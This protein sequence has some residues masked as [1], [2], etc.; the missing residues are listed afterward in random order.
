MKH[1][2]LLIGTL[3]LLVGL[4][5]L[6]LWLSLMGTRQAESTNQTANQVATDSTASPI[7][8]TSP[9]ATPQTSPAS[10]PHPVS[11][12]AI[13][14]KEFDGRDFTVGRVLAEAERY[15][16]YYITY[17]SGD[18]T[19]SGIMNKPKGEGPFPVLILNHGYIDPAVYTNGRGLKREQDYL[20]NNGYVVIH[21]DYRNHA[22]SSK[23]PDENTAFRLGYVEDVINAIKAVQA[24]DLS[25]VNKE[26]IGMLGHSMGG[27]ITLGILVTHPDLVKA[28]VLFAPVSASAKDNYDKYTANNPERARR[29][30]EQF[31]TPETQPELWRNVSPENF[32]DK[33]A[34]PVMVHHGT[35][36]DSTPIAWSNTLVDKLKQQNKD[37]AYHVYEGQPHEFT[38]AWPTVMQRTLDFF[39]M[40]L[41]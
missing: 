18:L 25:Y 13:A 37:V 28:A 35:I 36:D 17:K 23:A 6:G 29:V 26:K 9:L 33:V 20:A 12:Q 16:R 4:I 5:G 2:F 40:H 7:S 21:P 8:S 1:R 19:I 41:R 11:L 34:V 32:L 10:S 14:Q 24:S 38:S 39:N 31:G 27:G 22:E 15:T 3:I 30:V